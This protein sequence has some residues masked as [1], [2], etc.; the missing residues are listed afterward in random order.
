[1]PY[2]HCWIWPTG[3][4]P[5]AG[6][7]GAKHTSTLIPLCHNILLSKV[8]VELHLVPEAHAVDVTALAK[9]VS[10]GGRC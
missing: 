9:T 1:M 10:G 6:V 3:V 7:M 2:I 8:A 5:Y 4:I